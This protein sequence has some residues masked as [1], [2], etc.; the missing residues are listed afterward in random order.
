[1]RLAVGFS[2][3]WLS[4]YCPCALTWVRLIYLLHMLQLEEYDTRRFVHWVLLHFDRLA[5]N[6]MLD[7]LGL[8]RNRRMFVRL[9]SASSIIIACSSVDSC[10]PGGTPVG[11]SPRGAESGEESSG[12]DAACEAPAGMCRSPQRGGLHCT[13]R[14]TG[15]TCSG[16][17]VASADSSTSGPDCQPHDHGT[18]RGLDT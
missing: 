6:P 14:R 5:A 9:E 4:Q 1:M 12:H 7:L 3:P 18:A 2:L 10:W 16:G 11:T 15:G 8:S 13:I 17:S